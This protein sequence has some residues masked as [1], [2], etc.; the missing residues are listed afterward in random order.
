MFYEESVR[1][2]LLI[3]GHGSPVGVIANLDLAQTIVQLAG[4]NPH[5]MEMDGRALLP[6]ALNPTLALRHDLLI[7]RLTY[8]TVRNESFAFAK[9]KTGEQELYDLRRA[10][11]NYDPFKL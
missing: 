6:F 10:S 8:E 11:T 7:E 4:T 9:Y 3:R 1:V 2:P 5:F